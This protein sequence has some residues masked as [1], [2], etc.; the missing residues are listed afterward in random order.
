MTNVDAL[1]RKHGQSISSRYKHNGSLWRKNDS[2]WSDDVN[3]LKEENV[4]F[5]I[6]VG[7]DMIHKKDDGPSDDDANGSKEESI[8]CE[9][10]D[11]EDMFHK[12]CEDR[13]LKKESM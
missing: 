12:H 2:S 13:K 3:G 10:A 9:M 11:G 4:G 7:E 1:P 5:Q 6:A 8:G